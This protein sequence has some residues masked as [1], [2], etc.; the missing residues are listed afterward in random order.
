MLDLEP[1]WLGKSIE[2]NRKEMEELRK[3]LPKWLQDSMGLNEPYV[4][5]AKE[6]TWPYE[7]DHQ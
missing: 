2:R 7:C 3:T 1:G 6:E 5:K 4:E